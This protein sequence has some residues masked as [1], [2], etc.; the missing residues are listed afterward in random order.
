MRIAIDLNDVVR[1]FTYNF[2]LYY[3]KGYNHQYDVDELTEWTN[4]MQALLPFKTPRAYEKFVYED[5]SF[6]LFGKCPTCTKKLTEQLNDWTENTIKDLET[7]EPIEVMF[8][9]PMEY[10]ASIGNTY[11][12]IAKLATKIREVYLPSDSKTIWDRCDVLITA[13]PNLLA[14][15]PEGKTAIRIEKD[16][17]KESKCDYSYNTLSLFLTDDKIMEKITKNDR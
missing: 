12:F 14:E 17:N 13:N 5:Y 2:V 11:F 1:D 16:Y 7:E 8:V 3:V 10:G 15:K 6:E 4:D 9:S